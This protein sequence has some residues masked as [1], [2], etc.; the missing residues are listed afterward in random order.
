MHPQNTQKF[1]YTNTHIESSI[2]RHLPTPRSVIVIADD[3]HFHT[4]TKRFHTTNAQK[5]SLILGDLAALKIALERRTNKAADLSRPFL[6]SG[7]NE[8]HTPIGKATR[9]V[10]SC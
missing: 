8:H 5:L 4:N 2:G 1:Q 3:R 6:G 7:T 9:V 10:L